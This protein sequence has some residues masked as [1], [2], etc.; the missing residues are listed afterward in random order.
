MCMEVKENEGRSGLRRNHD[1]GESWEK[2]YS[3]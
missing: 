2:Y 1:G 3:G